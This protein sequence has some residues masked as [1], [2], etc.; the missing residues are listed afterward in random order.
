[1]FHNPFDCMDRAQAAED[2]NFPGFTDPYG[3]AYRHC[4][5]ACCLVRTQPPGVGRCLIALWD[6][7]NEDADNPNS[8]GDMAGEREGRRLPKASNR[9][10]EDACLESYPN[11]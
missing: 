7:L 10:C 6:L 4:V 5:A 8:Q 2:E 1:M 9:S 3:G 11:N